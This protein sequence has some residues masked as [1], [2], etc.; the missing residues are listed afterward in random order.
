M[1]NEE[2]NE[3]QFP[4]CVAVSDLIYIGKGLC[5]KHWK[6]IAGMETK[7]AYKKL[8][9]EIKDAKPSYTNKES[10]REVKRNDENIKLPTQLLLTGIIISAP[11][12]T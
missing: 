12:K 1:N 10:R 8:H 5:E 2:Q 3:C 6:V 9:I 7:D 4:K 11:K